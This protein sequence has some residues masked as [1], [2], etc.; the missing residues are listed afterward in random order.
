MMHL[1]R[2]SDDLRLY[3][4]KINSRNY[5]GNARGKRDGGTRGGRQIWKD[6]WR[7]LR[8]RRRQFWG[9][10]L[11][12]PSEGRAGTAARGAEKAERFRKQQERLGGCTTT[13]RGRAEAPVRE[14]GRL[15]P[16]SSPAVWVYPKRKR[17]PP[18]R[19]SQG[20]G[21]KDDSGCWERR[22]W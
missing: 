8:L 4:S 6:S 22:W 19:S 2:G 15:P 10:G 5:E 16:G 12:V 20:Y 11:R 13:C 9:V 14:E 18:E 21:V 1:L 17:K 3:R 7:S